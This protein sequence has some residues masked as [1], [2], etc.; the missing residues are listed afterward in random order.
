MI[1]H[2]FFLEILNGGEKKYISITCKIGGARLSPRPIACDLD[3]VPRFLCPYLG[4]NW[5]LD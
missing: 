3:Q 1:D 5:P 2:A 4:R